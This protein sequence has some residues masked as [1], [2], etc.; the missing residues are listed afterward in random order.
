MKKQT[1][2]YLKT[3]TLLFQHGE[4]KQFLCKCSFLEIYNEQIY[5]LLEP[6]SSSLQLRES[7]KTGV[8]VENLSEKVV[9]NASEAYEVNIVVIKF[10]F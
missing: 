4:N 1:D 9:N 8:Y 6:S 10:Y 5:D 7:L 2:C 3:F